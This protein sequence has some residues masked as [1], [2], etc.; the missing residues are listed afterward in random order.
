MNK[1]G[2]YLVQHRIHRK[3]PNESGQCVREIDQRRNRKRRALGAAAGW[4]VRF[5]AV[6]PSGKHRTQ[7][8][9]QEGGTPESETSTLLLLQKVN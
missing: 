2:P 1:K 6:S 8:W 4:T 7:R 9:K 3:L 5:V